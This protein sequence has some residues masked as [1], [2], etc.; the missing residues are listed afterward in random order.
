LLQPFE[1]ILRQEIL[2]ARK[3]SMRKEARRSRTKRATSPPD[4]RPQRPAQRQREKHGRDL[5]DEHL[6][7]RFV[8]DAA[9]PEGFFKEMEKAAFC[10]LLP[11]S[12]PSAALLPVRTFFACI[13]LLP[14]PQQYAR[15]EPNVA[16][17]RSNAQ[18]QP[19]TGKPREVSSH[20]S[21]Q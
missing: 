3:N 13:T 1:M 16:E 9:F 17:S 5:P 18:Y 2:S 12:P 10:A 7:Q 20:L 14:L 15:V 6:P 4:G 19:R 21:S 8:M 11:V